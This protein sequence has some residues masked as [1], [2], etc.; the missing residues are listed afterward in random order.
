MERAI[1]VK[2]QTLD[3]FLQT[4]G[5]K[6]QE[7][8]KIMTQLSQLQTLP[9]F[10]KI[11]DQNIVRC[12]KTKD[13]ESRHVFLFFPQ[14][15]PDNADLRLIIAY[16]ISIMHDIVAL[17]DQ[18]YSIVWVTDQLG[19]QRLGFFW[20]RHVYKMVPDAY[21]RNM[22]SLAVVHPTLKVRFSL[23]LLSYM[24]ARSFWDKLYYAD[25]VEFLDDLMDVDSLELPSEVFEYDRFLD[26]EMEFRA[27]Q[28][29]EM[30]VGNMS[31]GAVLPGM[32]ADQADPFNMDVA[33]RFVEFQHNE[34]IKSREVGDE[35]R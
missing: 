14:N 15:V 20:L 5:S 17:Q 13:R 6:H 25:R 27:K 31:T 19:P 2:P 32:N 26:Q 16:A 24:L 21:H 9:E 11:K 4:L 28:A 22:R 8:T 30:T 1:D 29:S 34:K 23:F 33:G 7:Y 3:K 12:A 10:Q 18:H 35:K